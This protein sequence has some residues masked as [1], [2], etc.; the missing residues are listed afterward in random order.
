MKDRV[1]TIAAVREALGGVP[2][3]LSAFTAAQQSRDGAGPFLQEANFFW[4]TGVSEPDWRCIVLPDAL[5]LVAP[6]RDDAYRTFEGGF[7][8][9]EALKVSGADACLSPGEAV[10]LLEEVRSSHTD[11]YALGA[12]PQQRYYS[13][14]SNPA[15]AALYDELAVLFDTVRDVRPVLAKLRALKTPAE[16]QHMRTAAGYTVAAYQAVYDALK[17]GQVTHEYEI[18]ALFTYEMR[19]RGADGHAYEPI[20]ASGSNALTLHYAKNSAQ[21]PKNGLVLMDVGARVNGYTADVTRTYAI[22]SPFPR[23][24]AVHAAVQ[25]AHQ[26]IIATIA[27]GVTFEEYHNKADASMKR[28]LMQLGLLD[29]KDDEPAYRKYFPHAISHGLGIDV[30]ESLGGGGSF[31]P[32]MVLTVEPGIY[33]PEEEIG[34]RIEDNILVTEDGN[35]N[36]TAE[37][38]TGL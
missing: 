29:S 12:D 34:V 30:H 5:Y 1:N 20:V 2:L 22:G 17:S 31:Q 11:V 32:G 3:V 35:E 33:I 23:E 19:R 27:P 10:A 15:P 16:L 6:Q 37:L 26:E 28:A 4:L 36:L 38:S 14:A 8:E 9:E 21:L 7:S 13:F 25:A 24:K 18:E